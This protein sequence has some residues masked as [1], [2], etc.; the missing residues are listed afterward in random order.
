MTLPPTI[1]QKNR[2][3]TQYDVYLVGVFATNFSL[4]PNKNNNP[5]LLVQNGLQKVY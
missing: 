1:N 4:I 2:T 5:M 3:S